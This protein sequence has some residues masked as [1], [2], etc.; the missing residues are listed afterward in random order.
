M[1]NVPGKER[2]REQTHISYSVTLAHTDFFFFFFFSTKYIKY[3]H[4]DSLW[5]PIC[6]TLANGC[7]QLLCLS[8]KGWQVPSCVATK[9]SPTSWPQPSTAV[10]SFS[11][12]TGKGTNPRLVSALKILLAHCRE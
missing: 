7:P 6:W 2:S 8:K 1:P 11:Q 4:Q 5:W 3:I 9:V 12:Q 10:Y